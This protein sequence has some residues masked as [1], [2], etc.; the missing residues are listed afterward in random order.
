MK[1]YY[2]RS[3]TEAAQKFKEVLDILPGDFNAEN[4]YNRCM[5]YASNPPPANWDGVE[6]MK[7]K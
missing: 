4:L 7:S 2:H 5:D 3:F 1:L 6:V